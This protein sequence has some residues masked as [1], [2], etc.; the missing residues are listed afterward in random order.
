MIFCAFGRVKVKDSGDV[1]A[2]RSRW[3]SVLMALNGRGYNCGYLAKLSELPPRT[4]PAKVSGVCAIILGIRKLKNYPIGLRV[5][6]LRTFR[7]SKLLVADC[8][9]TFQETY[10]AFDLSSFSLYFLTDS[11]PVAH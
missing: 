3:S 5:A 4:R 8:S 11:Y 10:F 7:F 1:D 9:S 2:S 6:V